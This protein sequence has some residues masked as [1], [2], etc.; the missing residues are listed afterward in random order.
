MDFILRGKTMKVEN[1][2]L[3]HE[4]PTK[5][6]KKTHAP[7]L[8]NMNGHDIVKNM[9]GPTQEDNQI[10]AKSIPREASAKAKAKTEEPD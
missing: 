8:K 3:H 6:R 5:K 4:S 7:P 10:A 2:D 9:K 1:E